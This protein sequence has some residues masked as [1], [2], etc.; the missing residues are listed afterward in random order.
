MKRIFAV[1]LVAMI[2][3]VSLCACGSSS[4]YDYDYDSYDTDYDS[5]YNSD[6][7]SDY[8]SYSSFTNDYGTSTTK[9]A[10]SGCNSYIA[11][12][13]DTNCCVVHS[14]NCLE[15]FCYIDGDAMYC[16]DC[17][18][19]AAYSSNDY[20]Y[21]Y[22]SDYGSYSSSNECY[23]CGG[24]AYSKYG[25]YYYCSSCLDLVKAFS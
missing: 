12:S 18:T 6:Y 5:D 7:D 10:K 23:I 19:D 22:D 21:D 16:M 20:D 3:C 1:I 24:S 15:C 4:S 17:L 11:S 14:N 9:C 8:D 13:G 2:L 25:S